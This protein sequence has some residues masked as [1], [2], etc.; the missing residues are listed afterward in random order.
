MY[1]QVDAGGAD[2]AASLTRVAGVT[3]SPISIRPS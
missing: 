1:L 3:R 2:P